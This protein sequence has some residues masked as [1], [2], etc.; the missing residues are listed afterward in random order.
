MTDFYETNRLNDPCFSQTFVL[1]ETRINYIVGGG[2]CLIN[3]TLID[4]SKFIIEKISQNI[5]IH[6]CNLTTIIDAYITSLINFNYIIK[7]RV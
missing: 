7:F 4:K 2:W 3:N 6:M 1:P 5:E